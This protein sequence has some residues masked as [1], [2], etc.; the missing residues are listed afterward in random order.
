VIRFLRLVGRM[1]DHVKGMLALD[2]DQ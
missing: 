1:D 2:A